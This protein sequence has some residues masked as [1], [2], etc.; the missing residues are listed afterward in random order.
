MRRFCAAIFLTILSL[1]PVARAQ[2]PALSEPKNAGRAEGAA[3]L[4][5]DPAPPVAPE[6]I[7]RDDDGHATVR[8]I[9]LASPLRVDGKLDEEVYGREKPFGG[10]IQVTP[11]YGAPQSERS[12]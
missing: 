9:K 1:S 10:F 11:E 2:E 8:A 3:V 12:D 7:A 6:V 4:R 5:G